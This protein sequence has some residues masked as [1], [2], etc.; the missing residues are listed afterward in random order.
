MPR[1][2]SDERRDLLKTIAAFRCRVRNEGAARQTDRRRPGTAQPEA[3]QE[4][5]RAGRARHSDP[6]GVRRRGSG[7]D[8][9]L[10]VPPG[11]P[12]RTGAHQRL[13]ADC[14]L[15]RGL[16]ELRHRGAE[17]HRT[18]RCGRGPGRGRLDVGTRPR[19]RGGLEKRLG[20]RVVERQGRTIAL[21]RQGRH[22][23]P[24]PERCSRRSTGCGAS[25]TRSCGRSPNDL[26]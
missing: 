18:R 1:V 7:V 13:R 2:L 12:L 17:A 21:P 15:G 4:D 22:C 23:C 8:G 16:R 26:S 19:L 11:I 9:P 24:K 14:H 25:P 6:G 3:V 10:P 20:V 5:G